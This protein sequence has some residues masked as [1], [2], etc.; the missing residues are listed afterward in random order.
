MEKGNAFLLQRLAAG[1]P[2]AAGKIG[3]S[4][5]EVLVAYVTVKKD[6]ERFFKVITDGH[7]LDLLHLNSGVF[8]K[9]QDVLVRWAET[10]LEALQAIDL[11]GVWHNTGER[12]IVSKFAPRATLTRTM[13]LEPYY[14]RAP[15][16]H[17]LVGKRVTVVTPFVDTI[18]RQYG[19][20]R[21]KDLFPD[22]PSVLGEFELSAVRAP[23]SAGLQRPVHE[24]WHAALDDL[25][26]SIAATEPDVCLIG[27]GAWSLPLCSFVRRTLNRSAVHLGGGL[28]LLFGVRGRRWESGHPLVKQLWNEN[29]IRALPQETPKR[30]WKNDG[31]AYW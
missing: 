7:Q 16:T 13:A 26:R 22:N 24:D 25:Q 6:P 29:W 11:L 4:E 12:E 17:A 10:F 27:A 31:G 9:R 18:S 20:Y 30:S 28:Q 2:T 1:E 8:P 19:M 3:D 5:L 23:F 14:H 15:W 21:G